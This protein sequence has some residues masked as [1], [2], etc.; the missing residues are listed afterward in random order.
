[1]GIQ[2]LLAILLDL[3]CLAYLPCNSS[4]G[5]S[6]NENIELLKKLFSGHQKVKVYTVLISIFDGESEFISHFI[7]SW[8]RSRSALQLKL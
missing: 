6:K 5:R 1:M 2:N 3:G 7:G 4:F 8:L